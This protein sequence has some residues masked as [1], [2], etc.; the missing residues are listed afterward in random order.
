M[1]THNQAPQDSGAPK[2]DESLANSKKLFAVVAYI[3]F[4]VPLLTE[5]KDDPYV[6]FHTKQGLVLFISYVAGFIV[7]IIPVIGWILA[8]IIVI[9]NLVLLIIGIFNAFGNNQKQLPIIGKYAD[10]FSL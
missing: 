10:K 9:M 5:F 4:F 3:L 2:K 1:E 7:G 6:K 8:P